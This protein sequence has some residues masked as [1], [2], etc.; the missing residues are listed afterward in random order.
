[1]DLSSGSKEYRA[2]LRRRLNVMRLLLDTHIALWAFV[3][4][5]CLQERTRALIE[6]EDNSI[7]VSAATIW[8]ISIKHAARRGDM[9]ISGDDAW[10]YCNESGFRILEITARHASTAGA[11]ENSCQK[12]EPSENYCLVVCES[13]L[14]TLRN[15]RWFQGIQQNQLYDPGKTQQGSGFRR[16]EHAID[17]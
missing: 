11:Q 5:P 4:S 13:G 2:F 12:Y 10:A 17:L 15:W 8:E 14:C 9:P 16:H 3:N 1:M 6:A 7:Y